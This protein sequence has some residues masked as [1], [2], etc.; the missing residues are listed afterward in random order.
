M[1]TLQTILETNDLQERRITVPEWGG[2]EILLRALSTA[3][4]RALRKESAGADGKIDEL[5]LTVH[6]IIACAY[7]SGTGEP[8]FQRT[9]R[10]ALMGKAP[11]VIERISTEVMRLSGLSADAAEVAE[12]N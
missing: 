2:V 12:K 3:Q 8:L 9:H 4:V 5:L 6:I 1:T 11:K 10:D 7:D